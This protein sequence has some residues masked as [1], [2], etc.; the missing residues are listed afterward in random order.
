SRPGGNVT[1]V[2]LYGSELAR[3]RME[4]FKEAVAGIQR[5][6]VPGNAENPLHR[7]LSVRP[8]PL[9]NDAIPDISAGD[10]LTPPRARE[11]INWPYSFSPRKRHETVP[12]RH[13][14]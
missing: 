14:H 6:A 11:R 8:P 9:S 10:L 7:F 3:K 1:G 12:V 5:I 2:S 4:V 13:F